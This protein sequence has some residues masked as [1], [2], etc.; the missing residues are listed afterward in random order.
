MLMQHFCVTQSVRFTC[1]K[2]YSP[3]VRAL[4][5]GINIVVV[6]ELKPSCVYR[7]SEEESLTHMKNHVHSIHG[8]SR[9]VCWQ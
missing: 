7:L 8:V 1:T 4:S 9:F 5:C 6:E 2:K 3:Q